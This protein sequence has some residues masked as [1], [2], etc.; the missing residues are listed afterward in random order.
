MGFNVTCFVF[1]SSKNAENFYNVLIKLVLYDY[2]KTKTIP[3]SLFL[4][5]YIYYFFALMIESF[6]FINIYWIIF[7][8]SY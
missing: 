2:W 7:L 4:D 5:K 6:D 1:K 8:A 3:L